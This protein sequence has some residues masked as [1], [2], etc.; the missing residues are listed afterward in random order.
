MRNKSKQMGL[1][2]LLLS[3][4]LFTVPLKA[5]VTI[6]AQTPPDNYSLLDL[7]TT[8]VKK[9]VHLPRM[10][11]TE[12]DA[13][14]PATAAD[15]AAAFGVAIYNTTT[16]C[17]EVWNAK[18]W[19]SLCDYTN[20]APVITVQPRVFSW[21][22]TTGATDFTGV[23]SPTNP[24]PLA[25]AT[26][27][28]TATGATSYQW[29]ELS[30]TGQATVAAGTSNLATYTPD[31]SALGMKQYYC[32]VSNA[33]GSTKSN[34]AK[35]A[36]GCG[37]MTMDG[38]WRTFMCYN[39]GAS[40]TDIA[41]QLAYDG[42]IYTTTNLGPVPATGYSGAAADAS[43]YGDLYQWGRIPDGHQ[44]R[45]SLNSATTNAPSAGPYTAIDTPWPDGS[46]QIASGAPDYGKFVRVNSF[47]TGNG[48]YAPYDWNVNP[49]GRNIW[50]WRNYR[51]AQNDPCVHVSGVDGGD[52]LWRIPTQSEWGDIWRG[53]MSTSGF[54]TTA[55]NTANTWVW[56]DASNPT[57]GAT[58]TAGGYE[59]KPDGVTTTLFLPAAGNRNGRGG[60][61]YYPSVNGTYWSSTAYDSNFS[62]SLNFS[63]GGVVPAYFNNF[64]A[65][66]N[67]VRCVAEL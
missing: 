5:Q 22:E 13:L 16:N 7:V 58:G 1:A 29:Y 44:L 18:Q 33:F 46:E 63:I 27:S 61:L 11:T 30:R 67:S 57:D 17:N 51:Y 4:V 24:A 31:G 32:L 26:I 52:A 19:L 39:L 53:G 10:N 14:I 25:I 55:S 45:S 41:G 12:R 64:R 28:V 35:V 9:G 8:N 6:G 34:I 56:R 47:S 66:G 62:Y 21:K 20:N 48:A 37:A 38:G 59:I 2:M 54:T 3:A 40:I 60:Q 42:N 15:S 23:T 49:T 43:V 65:S 36:V 50:L